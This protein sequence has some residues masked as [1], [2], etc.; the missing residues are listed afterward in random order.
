MKKIRKVNICLACFFI[1]TSF[2][3]GCNHSIYQDYITS[4]C[5]IVLGELNY[6]GQFNMPKGGMSDH[7]IVNDE[8]WAF[9]VSDDEHT[10]FSVVHRY[11][12]DIQNDEYEYVGKFGHNFGHCNTVD[13]CSENDTLVLGNGG[14]ANYDLRDQIYIIENASNLKN[15]E[16]ANLFDVAK[17]IDLDGIGLDFGQQVNVCWGD[18]NYGKHNIIYAISNKD[19]IKYIRKILLGTGKNQL[20]YGNLLTV[21]DNEFNGT[22]KILNEFCKDYSSAYCNQGTQYYNGKIYEALGHDGLLIAVNSLIEDKNIKTEFLRTHFYDVNG[23]VSPNTFS[24]GIAI[25]NGYLFAGSYDYYTGNKIII[26][27]L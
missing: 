26:Y 9:Y 3:C 25:K 27:K 8:L 11:K 19:G 1:L 6:F 2:F 15:S 22:F 5:T 7:T 20:Q 4:S 17:V 21:A 16:N 12:I 13:Y 10:D 18:S 23:E 24:E 14:Q